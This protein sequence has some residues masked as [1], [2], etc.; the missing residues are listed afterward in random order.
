[1]LKQKMANAQHEYHLDE[2]Y[3]GE[4]WKPGNVVEDINGLRFILS[5]H[6]KHERMV[7]I[8]PLGEGADVLPTD[9]CLTCAICVHKD[10]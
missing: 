2:Y 8:C 4:N 3:L 10:S 6:K 5:S 9:I 1:M 7:V